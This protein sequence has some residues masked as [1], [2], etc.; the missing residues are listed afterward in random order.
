[1][2]NIKIY[3]DLS[4]K[5]FTSI[6]SSLLGFLFMFSRNMG[7]VKQNNYLSIALFILSILGYLAGVIVGINFLVTSRGDKLNVK[8]KVCVW[9]AIIIGLLGLSYIV[10]ANYFLYQLRHVNYR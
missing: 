5:S 9:I 8:D 1:M 10:F 2:K 4:K 3:N 6:I 7:V